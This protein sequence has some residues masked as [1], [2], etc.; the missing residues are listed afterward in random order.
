ME[1][2]QTTKRECTVLI[3]GTRGENVIVETPESDR[4][5]HITPNERILQD[6]LAGLQSGD[7]FV[8]MFS[9][10]PGEQNR[11]LRIV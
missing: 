8:G 3:P 5:I 1:T 7:T 4:S 10:E 2:I 6:E 9:T 11:L